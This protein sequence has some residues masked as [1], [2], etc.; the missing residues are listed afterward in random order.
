MTR[1]DPFRP[2]RD[3][4]N[5]IIERKGWTNLDVALRCEVYPDQISRVRRGVF[6]RPRIDFIVKLAHGLGVEIEDLVP[7]DEIW[8]RMNPAP[9]SGQ[10]RRRR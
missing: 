3:R 9:A 5:R 8:E 7:V 1:P 10:R 4:L 2:F 6:T